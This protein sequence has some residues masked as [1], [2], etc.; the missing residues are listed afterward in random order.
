MNINGRIKVK[1]LK[2]EFKKE[3]GLSLRIYDGRSFADE[4]ST[5]AI[6]FGR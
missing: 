5:L 2:L 3:F 1:T 6:I 4:N